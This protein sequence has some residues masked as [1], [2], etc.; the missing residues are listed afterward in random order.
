MAGA[1]DND[2][3]REAQLHNIDAILIEF[4]Y[5]LYNQNDKI[6]K[7]AEILY[8]YIITNEYKKVIITIPHYCII[9]KEQDINCDMYIE[10]FSKII[11]EYLKDKHQF[12]IIYLDT[13]IPRNPRYYRDMNRYE[14]R[15]EPMRVKLRELLNDNIK[16]ILFDIHSFPAGSFNEKEETKI[17]LLQRL[18]KN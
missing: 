14:G 3:I 17:V 11:Y 9:S 8:D 7:I 5:V 16:T 2:I 4:N 18:I 6:K 1:D 15:E 13:S 10:F 12:E